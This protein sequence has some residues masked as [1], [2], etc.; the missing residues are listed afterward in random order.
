LIIA[1]NHSEPDEV[2]FSLS[3][4][5]ESLIS[6][7][8]L[9]DFEKNRYIDRLIK[10]TDNEQIEILCSELYQYQPVMGYHSTPTNITEAA[11]AVKIRLER[12]P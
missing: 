2:D 12:E 4:Y 9:Y 8:L 6:Q 5:A 11:L 10:C 3:S 7:A 1:S